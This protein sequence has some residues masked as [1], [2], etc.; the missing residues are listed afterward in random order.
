[1]HIAVLTVVAC[2]S[3]DV[4]PQGADNVIAA[5]QD[6]QSSK[7]RQS[8]SSATGAAI[9]YCQFSKKSGRLDKV[10][11][12]QGP[13]PHRI[14]GEKE[15][16]RYKT[17]DDCRGEDHSETECSRSCR[18]GRAQEKKRMLCRFDRQFD[19]YAHPLF[20]GDM[21]GGSVTANV[22]DKL[23]NKTLIPIREISGQFIL[24]LTYDTYLCD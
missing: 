13:R 3:K 2:F 19:S 16:K 21:A 12:S 20:G 24:L 18:V 22:L 11:R 4:D 17:V 15:R 10:P 8:L 14:K 9:T 7:T 1:M 23:C 6:Y 5:F